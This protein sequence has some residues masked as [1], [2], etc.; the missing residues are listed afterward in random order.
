M[1]GRSRRKSNQWMWKTLLRRKRTDVK[2]LSARWNRS[3]VCW[4]K[5]SDNL[6]CLKASTRVRLC[7]SL[8]EILLWR[9]YWF[10]V[11]IAQKKHFHIAF[12]WLESGSLS[13][14]TAIE[15]KAFLF[16]QHKNFCSFHPICRLLSSKCICLWYLH[17]S[18]SLE[19][20]KRRE[21]Q[22][23]FCRELRKFVIKT[24]AAVFQREFI[25]YSSHITEMKKKTYRKSSIK[26]YEAEKGGVLT[27]ETLYSRAFYLMNVSFNLGDATVWLD[28]G[29]KKKGFAMRLNEK[30]RFVQLFPS[31]R[32]LTNSLFKLAEA[33]RRETSSKQQECLMLG[34]RILTILQRRK[35]GVVFVSLISATNVNKRECVS[36]MEISSNIC[37]HSHHQR[38]YLF[39]FFHSIELL[40][41]RLRARISISPT[42]RDLSM[43]IVLKRSRRSS[44]LTNNP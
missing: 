41:S 20:T 19:R 4:I 33:I 31:P 29:G 18:D 42:W 11:V 12:S 2:S 7:S 24:R 13:E 35:I 28:G 27:Q 14:Y 37:F 38:F 30:G 17:L 10:I 16:N 9:F 6:V 43:S 15:T 44:I 5:A 23:S 25:F 22:F 32:T 26:P 34:I 39:E 8:K 36:L 40:C 1:L 3:S 21:L